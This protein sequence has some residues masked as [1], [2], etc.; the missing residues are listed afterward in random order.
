M[1]N[2]TRDDVIA[3][4]EAL[5]GRPPESEA[6]IESHLETPSAAQLIRRFT[7]STEFLGR[8]KSSPFH[9]YNAAI[10]IEAVIRAHENPHRQAKPGHVVNFLGAAMNVAFVPQVEGH[11]GTVEG[12]PIPANWHADMAEFG[13]VLRAV[14]LAEGRFTMIELGCGWGCWMVN[15]GVAA[16]RRNLP[17]GLIGVEGDPGHVAFAQEALATNGIAAAD[18]TLIRGIAGAKAGVALFPR[19]TRSGEHW[20]LQPKFDCSADERVDLA[21][22]GQYEEVPIVALADAI[23]GEP[24]ID[25][26]HMD[27][28]GGEASLIRECLELL[29]RKVAY[30]V[31][32]THSRTIEGE[33]MAL[34]LGAGW[35]L[36]IERPAIL[37]I[38]PD[39]P[40]TIVDGVQGWRNDI[41]ARAQGQ[42]RG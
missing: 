11:A 39:G 32:G 28:Q 13:A 24:R 22:M 4:Y 41:A 37:T 36:E 10:N 6:A 23:G 27:I 7:A 18:Y 35:K 14:D 8:W 30:I 19:Q 12:P 21:A 38:T 5:L 33:L 40:V 16:K 26:L 9:H 20:G 25:L 31:I 3:A 2:L 34:L 17:I 42:A 1:S 15:S 29:T